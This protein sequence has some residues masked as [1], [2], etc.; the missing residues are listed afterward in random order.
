[1]AL[2]E[3]DRRRHAALELLKPICISLMK[4]ATKE[5]VKALNNALHEVDDRIVQEIQQYILFPIGTRLQ[6]KDLPETL[7]CELCEVVVTLFQKT[8]VASLSSFF[9]IFNPLMFTLTPKDGSP[10]GIVE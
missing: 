8:A 9:E 2:S 7:L 4:D 6:L 1:M 3:L 5:R 10:R